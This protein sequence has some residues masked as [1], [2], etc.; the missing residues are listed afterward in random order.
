ML[1]K[2]PVV[3]KSIFSVMS[4]LSKEERA[5]NLSQGFPE[6]DC[7][8]ALKEKVNFFIESGNNQYAPMSGMPSLRQSIAEK[9]AN[10]LNT[11]LDPDL[12]IT[13]TAGAT[14]AIYTA[15][16]AL[17]HKNDEVIVFDPAYDC[18]EPA[19]TING[20]IAKHI[21]LN[22]PDYG[23]PWDEVESVL[24]AKT[25]LI[26]INSPHNPSGATLSL[27]DLDQLS[28]LCNKHN[29]FVLSDEVYEHM[30]FDGIKHL[31][32]LS[33][34]GLKDRSLATYSFGKTYHVTGWKLGYC[35]GSVELMKEFRKIHEYMVFSCNTPM[36]L[37]VAEHMK[38]AHYY[39]DLSSFFEEKR[40]HFLNLMSKSR[41]KALPC[42]GTYFQLMD[43]SAITD[44]KDTDF[45]IQLTK[46][47]KVASIPCSVF[48][49]D[50]TDNKVLRFC[51][52]KN[53]D[54]L[55]KA[56]EILCKI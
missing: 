37:A 16:T 46:E 43:Y 24:N 47:Y 35:A 2:I 36:Q 44:E 40:D 50:Q 12:Q 26:I 19:I 56:A 10:T 33:H 21:K 51:F 31:S 49:E 17:V 45:A 41:F 15:I 29:V 6:F 18:Y 30:T 38:E 1:S 55:T 3:Q 14:Q 4:A 7:S 53:N 25:K 20:G 28:E 8:S 5:I 42:N 27:E 13:V 32:V 34:E 11:D 48:Y 23:V 9:V 39:Q 22:F 54:T 52:A